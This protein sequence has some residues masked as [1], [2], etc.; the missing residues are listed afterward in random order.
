MF[1]TFAITAC[2]I[3]NAADDASIE[4][5]RTRDEVRFGLIGAKGASPAPTLFVFA[6]S[7][8][9]MQKQPIYTQA[10]RGLTAQGYL[11]VVIDAPCHGDDARAGEPAE[12]S[13]WRHRLEH[14][15]DFIVAFTGK[16]SAVLDHLIGEGYTDPERVAAYGTS[17]GGFLAVHFAAADRRVRAVAGISPVTNL[18]SVREFSDT[19]ARERTEELSLARLAPKL[20]TCAI[21]LSIGNH[22]ER[23]NTDDAIDFTRA[24]VRIAAARSN[25]PS[26]VIPVELLVAPAAGHTQVDQANELLAAWIVKQFEQE[27]LPREPRR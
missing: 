7:L 3:S 20:D 14:D 23:V 4:V 21:W 1:L 12:L 2:G 5:L 27:R 6:H 15:D 11:G 26:A 19:Q 10:A 25:D 18:L 13:G 22:D 17:R 16:A 8:E 24:V 9:T